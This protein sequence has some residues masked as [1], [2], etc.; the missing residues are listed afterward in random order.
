MLVVESLEGN[1]ERGCGE[2]PERTWVCIKRLNAKRMEMIWEEGFLSAGCC[3]TKSKSGE[4]VMEDRKEDE[5]P[6]PESQPSLAALGSWWREDLWIGRVTKD[7]RWQKEGLKG[8]S[9]KN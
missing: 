8:V 7:W 6:L 3:R 1:V 4:A 9:K 5:G 2:E